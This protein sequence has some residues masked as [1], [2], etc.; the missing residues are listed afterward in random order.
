MIVALNESFELGELKI[1]LQHPEFYH[2]PGFSEC[3]FGKKGT[4]FAQFFATRQR[5][6]VGTRY[7]KHST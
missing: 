2:Y 4:E 6:A 5:F 3:I 7:M 1:K